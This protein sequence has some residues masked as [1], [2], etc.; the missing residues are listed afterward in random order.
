[1]ISS[2]SLKIA[3]HLVFCPSYTS[4]EAVCVCRT[5]IM[6][7]RVDLIGNVRKSDM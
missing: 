2:I 3:V 4:S 7:K 1:M 6:L 5:V